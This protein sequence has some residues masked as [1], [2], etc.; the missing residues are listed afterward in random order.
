MSV[1]AKVQSGVPTKRRGRPVGAGI[2][3]AKRQKIMEGAHRVFHD[4]GFDTA[5]MQQIAQTAGV[6]KG[7]LYVYFANKED[8]FEALVDSQRELMFGDLKKVAETAPTLDQ[9]LF[10][11]GMLFTRKVLSDNGITAQRVLLGVVDR[12]P[13]LGL[14]FY[15]RGP[16][17]GHKLLQTLLDRFNKLEACDIADTGLA[18]YQFAELCLAQNYR[19]RLFGWQPQATSEDDIIKVVNAAVS[20]FMKA[21]A[22][23]RPATGTKTATE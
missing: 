1:E 22:C 19:Q 23:A 9:A 11:Y 2:D 3:P 7:T 20:L 14:Q 6:S 17:R 21:Y 18:A 13:E 5:S 15:E 12:Q 8:L 4:F 16:A 10:D